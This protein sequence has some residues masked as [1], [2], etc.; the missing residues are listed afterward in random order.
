[1][2][3][4]DQAIQ[5]TLFAAPSSEGQEFARLLKQALDG[6]TLAGQS[7]RLKVITNG[8]QRELFTHSLSDDVVIFDGS[9]ED[10]SGSNYTA[11][12]MFPCAFDHVLVVSRTRLPLN[13]QPFVPGGSPDTFTAGQHS[14][15]TRSNDHLLDW[16]IA[17]LHAMAPRLPRP[18]TERLHLD[19]GR[20]ASV[21]A[22]NDLV[23]TIMANSM[24]R[25]H[26][27]QQARKRT[28][29]S[30]LSRYS[31]YHRAPLPFGNGSVEDA[32]A[33]LCRTQAV[34][35]ADVLYYPP[36]ALASELMT[37]HRRWQVVALIMNRVQT[38]DEFWILETDD[39]YNSWWT[40][41]ELAMLALIRF[42]G[43]TMPRIVR[44]RASNAGFVATEAGSDFLPTPTA[45]LVREFQRFISNSDPATMGRETIPGL[46][47]LSKLPRVLQ[48]L[49]YKTMTPVVDSYL[50]SLTSNMPRQH[51]PMSAAQPEHAPWE[52][53]QF[54]AL[55]D[56]PVNQEAF[57]S[58][59]IITCP[60]CAGTNTEHS[61]FAFAPFVY[62]RQPG[63]Y[64]VAAAELERLLQ[65]N[66]WTC[67]GPAC[68]QVYTLIERPTTHFFWWP[69]RVKLRSPLHA[70]RVATGPG[71]V[72]V[73]RLPV[74]DLQ[75]GR[76]KRE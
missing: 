26:A 59:R 65:H 41:A 48:W 64:R 62:H 75:P 37:E 60:R 58:D 68:K 34:D 54:Q 49:A 7:L 70:E 18:H 36:G 35:P 2:G 43:G 55:L 40:M 4:S 74:Y 12:N 31:R 45:Q 15:F 32:I 8:D 76:E 46:Q 27:Q 19:G 63:Q 5:V 71:G 24:Q 51:R 22:I 9:V 11:T 1:M 14:P 10:A 3:S 29:M 56:S 57:W 17:Q 53:E 66:A 6:M 23:V 28:F 72:L 52:W 21:A 13:F 44:L 69:M 39:Y 20:M 47:R 61:H 73:E 30:Y 16:T 38:M 42:Q 25:K 67:P 50:R 33:Y